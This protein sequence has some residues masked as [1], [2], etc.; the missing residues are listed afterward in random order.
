MDNPYVYFADLISEIPDTPSDS[1]ISRT[2]YSDERVK[3]VLFGF[4]PG[5]ELSEHTASTPAL[6]Y[7]MKGEG[8]LTLGGDTQRVLPGAWA[9]MN[10]QLAH[11][12]H[13]DT[14]LV[15]LLVLIR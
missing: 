9:H 2:I 7:F 3:V 13:A 6:L 1:I 14:Q 15:M 12:I 5:Q 11:S 10:P 8:S 4:A